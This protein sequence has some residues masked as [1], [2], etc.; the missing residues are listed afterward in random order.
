MTFQE[1]VYSKQPLESTGIW[2][3]KSMSETKNNK[4]D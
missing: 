3:K 4:K 1:F 2:G